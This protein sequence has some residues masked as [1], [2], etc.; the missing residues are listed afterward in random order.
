M[1]PILA[2]LIGSFLG[3]LLAVLLFRWFDARRERKRRK[4]ERDRW[5]ES[6]GTFLKAT[7]DFYSQTGPAYYMRDPSKLKLKIAFH[8][9]REFRP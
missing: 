4:A 1:D 9:K 2:R 6:R 3:A 7:T 5:R 8:E